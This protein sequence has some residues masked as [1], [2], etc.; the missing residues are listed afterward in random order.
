MGPTRF[1]LTLAFVLA[2]GKAAAQ[3]RPDPIANLAAYAERSRAFWHVPGVAVAVVKDDSVVFLR[4][5]G[6]GSV[7]S[8]DSVTP[9]TIFAIASVTKTFTGTAI[10][11]LADEGKLGWDD[12]VTR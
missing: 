5:F 8:A 10:A 12:R 6:I 2:G 11:M 9:E 4:G 1:G 3:P 7:G